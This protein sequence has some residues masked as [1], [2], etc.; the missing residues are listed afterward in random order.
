[1]HALPTYSLAIL[2]AH[3]VAALLQILVVLLAGSLLTCAIRSCQ[4]HGGDVMRLTA[5]SCRA[6]AQQQIDINALLGPF[7]IFY[8]GA[9]CFAL[10]FYTFDIYVVV[11]SFNE[12][13]VGLLIYTATALGMST[14]SHDVHQLT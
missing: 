13:G 11:D 5:A 14:I 9:T 3:A 6:V 7:Y 1:M 10:M 8:F 2:L 4:A 12:Y